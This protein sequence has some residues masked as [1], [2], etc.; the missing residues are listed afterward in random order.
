MLST[1]DDATLMKVAASLGEEE[2][3]KLI[4]NLKNL[5]EITDDEIANKTG[6]QTKFCPQNPLQTLRSLL[7]ES[8]KN[9][10]P[11]DWMVHFPLETAT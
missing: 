8:E 9:T 4:E 11:Q 10:R 3:V 7:G 1:I 2:A 5:D 6:I